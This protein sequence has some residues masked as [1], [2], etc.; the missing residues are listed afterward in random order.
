MIL[1]KKKKKTERERER[2]L[3]EVMIASNHIRKK[4]TI[5]TI[6]Q[7]QHYSKDST[8]VPAAKPCLL[9]GTIVV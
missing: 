5:L 2:V 4:K 1:K 6:C 3:T 7:E 8:G 9:M